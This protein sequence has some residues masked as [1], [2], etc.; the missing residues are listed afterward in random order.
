MASNS[1][2]EAS[3]LDD[4]TRGVCDEAEEDVVPDVCEDP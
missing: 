4:G 3:A 1:V 2:I